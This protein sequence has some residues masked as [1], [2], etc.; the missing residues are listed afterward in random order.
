[1]MTDHADSEIVTHRRPIWQQAASLAARAHAGQYRN[2]GVTPYSAH[3]TRVALTLATVFGVTDEHLL[4]AALL[5]DVIEDTT[6][7]FDDLEEGFDPVVG[8]LVAFLSKD[9]RRPKREREGLYDAQLANAP[10]EARLLKLADVY[11][12]LSEVGPEKL[13]HFLEIARRAVALAASDPELERARVA[14]QAL[15]DA[16]SKEE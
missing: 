11:D 14:V 4:S 15:I 12:N 10:W 1:M 8:R 3:T 5:H 2:D 7:D 9:M 16:R 6:L 13:G